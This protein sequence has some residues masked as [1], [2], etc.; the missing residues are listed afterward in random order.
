MSAREEILGRIRAALPAGRDAVRQAEYAEIDR[1]Y[2]AAPVLP[3]EEKIALFRERL[4][5]YNAEVHRCA[6]AG[7]AATVA[8]VLRARGKSGLL[9]AEGTPGGWLPDGF[10]FTKDDGQAY[11][12]LDRS[13]GVLTGCAAAIAL[14]GTIVVRHGSEQGRRAL[15]LVPDYHLCVVPL[16]L[17]VE[18]VP[19][20]LR[21]MAAMLPA[22]LTTISGP[23]ATA[24][25]EMIRVKGVHGPRTLEVILVG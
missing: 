16:E 5:D 11:K 21:R 7:V 13:E 4:E 2:Q 8:Q 18:T 25:I 15:S 6:P 20:G 19:E 14:T 12:E 24:D 1:Q 17:L 23:S 3:L 10:S 9:I 22:P